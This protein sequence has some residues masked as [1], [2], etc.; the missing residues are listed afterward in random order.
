MRNPVAQ[1]VSHV[2]GGFKKGSIERV[3]ACTKRQS[4][5]WHPRTHRSVF[6]ET[7][8]FQKLGGGPKRRPKEGHHH[9]E[10]DSFLFSWW[11]PAIPL[12]FLF[13]SVYIVR[14]YE[15]TPLKVNHF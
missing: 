8:A 12:A 13:F 14:I 2:Q 4:C 5:L 6:F 15:F 9:F 10:V 11:F 7:V 3:S 1:P